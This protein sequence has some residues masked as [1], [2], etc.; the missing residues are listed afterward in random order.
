MIKTILICL[1]ATTANATE[2]EF[3]NPVGY[4]KAASDGRY[5]YKAGDVM[6]GPLQT[7]SLTVTGAGSF[8]T[9]VIMGAATENINANLHVAKPAGKYVGILLENDT[10]LAAKNAAGTSFYGMA[11]VTSG[12]TMQIGGFDPGNGSGAIPTSLV[13]GGNEAVGIYGAN[14]V[15]VPGNSFTVGT[16]T[17]VVKTGNVG[18]GTTTPGTTLEIGT[19]GKISMGVDTKANI[20]AY[21]PVRAGEMIYC[22]DCSSATICISTGTAVADF[23]DIGDRTAPCN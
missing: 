1:L 2:I 19:T 13:Y 14:D 8:G 11:R 10:P 6:S 16:S 9:P 22:S 3:Y 20:L 12:N 7:S 5:V 21:D 17:F 15:R 18:I 4:G 23:A